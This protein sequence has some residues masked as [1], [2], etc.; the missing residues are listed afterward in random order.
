MLKKEVALNLTK[1]VKTEME[2][3]KVLAYF[4]ATYYERDGFLKKERDK[5]ALQKKEYQ[6]S[7]KNDFFRT[8]VGTSFDFANLYQELCQAVGLNA[9]VIE[10]YVGRNIHA[11]GAVRSEQKA[12]RFASAMVF[13]KSDLSLI[14]H[15]AAW[16]AVEVNGKWILVDTYLMIKG[17]KYAYKNVSNKR[18]MERILEQNKKK[19]LTIKK[20]SIDENY[21]DATPKKMSEDHFPLDEKWQLLKYPVK[22]QNFIKN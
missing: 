14:R 18:S 16:N 7:Y 13:G 9:V 3:A 4:I 20:R 12:I 11:F 15:E 10:G 17:E 21:F 19:R 2:K 6:P 22:W 8:G 5:A 1:G